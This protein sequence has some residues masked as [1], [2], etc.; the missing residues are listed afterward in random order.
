MPK[1]E[2]KSA[3]I[4][5]EEKPLQIDEELLN[6]ISSTD[7]FK[8]FKSHIEGFVDQMGLK[9]Y[10]DCEQIAEPSS[11]DDVFIVIAGGVAIL[12]DDRVN[13]RAKLE[14]RKIRRKRKKAI[15][16]EGGGTAATEAAD[17]DNAQA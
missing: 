12:E 13:K 1:V 14:V 5:T 7:T 15:E 11:R 8:M 3:E 2:E 10:K 9:R 6:F 4:V 17:G 16:K